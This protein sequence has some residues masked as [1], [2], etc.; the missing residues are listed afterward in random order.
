MALCS[1]SNSSD[2]LRS[3]RNARRAGEVWR[4]SM[5]VSVSAASTTAC[6][7]LLCTGDSVEDTMRVPIWMPSAPEG[8]AVGH[9]R[10]V[11]HP[12]GRD[13]R[14][15]DPRAHQREQHHRGDITRVLEATTL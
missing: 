11:E 1:V 2:S 13:D 6:F 9:R 10:A 12:T 15:V 14:H 8:E 5:T 4:L 3:V 7:Q